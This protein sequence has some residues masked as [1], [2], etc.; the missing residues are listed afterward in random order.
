MNEIT[1]KNAIIYVRVSSLEQVDGTSLESQERLCNEYAKREGF[2]V[3]QTYIERGESAK[4]ADR[5]EFI[6]AISFCAEKK[7]KVTTFIVY[8]ID[9]FSRN[10]TDYAIVKQKLKKYGTEIRS[11]S[12]KIDDTPSGKLMEVML[13]GFAEFD[14]NVRTE[15]SIGGMKERLKKGIWVWQAPLGYC[16][17]EK[18]GNLVPDP[19]IAPYIKMAFEE[20]AKGTYTYKSLAKYLNE[21][22]FISRYG[23]PVIF[24]MVEKI[25]KNPLYCGIIRVWDTEMK[26]AFEPLIDENLF[27]LCQK[28][29]K[30]SR[31]VK[32]KKI[33]H[34]F[35]LRKLAVCQFCNDPLTGSRSTSHTGKRY[36]Y[37]HHHNK[38]CSYAKS[39]PKENFEQMFVEFLNEITPSMEYENAFKAIVIDI[40]KN[41][42]KGFDEEN[43][44]LRKEI[45][46][47][48]IKRQR[49][50]ELHQTKVYDDTD[51]LAQKNIICKKIAQK[52]SMIHDKR[53][54]E[55]NM[56]EA[57]D[58]C[59]DTVRNTANTWLKCEKEPEERLRFQNFIFEENIQFSGSK[60]GT[61]KLTPIYSMYQEFLLNPSSLVTLQ[62][63]EL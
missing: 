31:N 54:D 27:Y 48:E 7:N 10:Q 19:K 32:H 63:I 23:Q 55:F 42:Y 60:F 59:F 30:T 50:F 58:F 43:K 57:L 41:N 46:E 36:P 2:T 21:K 11:V 8:K 39:I 35:P 9:R 12:E 24:Q 17:T 3:L 20:Y 45:E 52:E 29:T 61:T 40:W 16:R 1:S 26:G 28:P 53:V 47:L 15:R 44:I 49:I 22:G 62:R 13:S 38:K 56:E 4:T 37:Y 51:F 25:L 34:D 14:N 5:T 33:N 6:K 18:G